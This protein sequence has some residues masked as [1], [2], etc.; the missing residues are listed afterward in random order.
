VTFTSG[1]GHVQM[2]IGTPQTEWSG[3]FELKLAWKIL[4]DK[5][6]ASRFYTQKA[7]IMAQGP[8]GK[9]QQ[10]LVTVGLVGMH[11][12]H[13]SESSPQWIW[14]TFEQVDNLSV[15]QVAHPAVNPSFADPNC[16][17][18][19]INVQPQPGANGAFPHTPTQVWR[20]IPIPADKV[21]LNDQ[22]EAALG[23]L[24]SVLQYYQLIDT[25]WPTQPNVAPANPLGPL[26]DS[27]TN[28]PGGDP[29]PVFL[30]NV[31]METY[32]QGGVQPACQGAELPQGV[33][34][35]PATPVWSSPMNAKGG[36]MPT[37]ATANVFISESCMGC[38]SS[39]GVYTSYNAATQQGSQSG[40]LSADFSWLLAQKAQWNPNQH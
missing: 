33:A 12:G 23:K 30:T 21:T 17:I 37:M 6:D 11:I 36:P 20:S 3:A 18:C 25:Q 29:T 7:Y 2:P 1:G 14:A 27:V 4:T 32:F 35:P 39:A 5:D 13:K 38:H 22:A 15:D 40:Q 31:T 24:G 10:Q 9:P 8:D 34:C 19:T 26:P 16:P 28:K